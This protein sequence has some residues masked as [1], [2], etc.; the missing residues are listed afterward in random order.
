MHPASWLPSRAWNPTSVSSPPFGLCP[1]GW[2]E[3]LSAG[4]SLQLLTPS[5]LAPDSNPALGCGQAR[6]KPEKAAPPDSARPG[7][8][9]AGG[10]WEPRLV[11]LVSSCLVPIGSPLLPSLPPACLPAAFLGIGH[12]RVQKIS[13]APL[14]PF[15]QG[16]VPKFMGF[17]KN[18]SVRNL[19]S[20]MF[21]GNIFPCS[22]TRF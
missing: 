8:G 6:G 16:I 21:M 18:G 14:A 15:L 13:E 19:W 4:W 10:R 12:V 3:V 1:R 5:P 17:G 7:K 20:H 22:C 11:S 9:T 2:G